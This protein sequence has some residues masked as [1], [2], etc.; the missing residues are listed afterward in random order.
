M[1]VLY[2][3]SP[4]IKPTLKEENIEILRPQNEPS[5]PSFSL[6]SILLPA[7]MT[8][9]SIGFFIYMNLSGKMGN[10]NYIMFQMVS[11]MMMLTSYTIPFFVYLSNKKKYKEQ[12]KERIRL[13]HAELDKHK[14]EFIL[15][16]KEQVDVLFEVHG[17][18]DVCFHVVKNRSSVLWERSFED[19]DFL[20][21]R[22]GTGSLPFYMK[23]K[24]PRPD[25]YVK[26]PLLEAAQELADEYETVSNAPIALP[27]FQAKVIGIV[28]DREAVMNSL[29]VMIAQ[30][31]VRH[32]PDEVKLAAFYEEKDAEDWDWMRWLP[33]TWDEQRSQR[34]M[35]DRRSSAHQLADELFQRLMRRKTS[36]NEQKKKTAELPIQLVLLSSS[37]L[38][39]EEPLLPLLLEEPGNVDACT[40]ILSDR[41]ETLPMPL[42][43]SY[44][45]EA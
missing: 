7:V 26:D 36:R 11:V 6:I 17:D 37:Q 12:L 5:K 39:E 44:R 16:H 28:G 38:I 14:E 21:T 40:I 25:G 13:Y 29:R 1:N 34:Y 35:S 9:F 2:Q 4:R 22:V 23:I 27:L 42:C 19:D 10:N 15:G 20:H 45:E 24:T 30:M 33:H 41:K 43:P 8:L 3:R 31:A 18:P 32:S